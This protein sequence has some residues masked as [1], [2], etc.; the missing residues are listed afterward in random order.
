METLA[1]T[2]FLTGLTKFLLVAIKSLLINHTA[3]YLIVIFRVDPL[4]LRLN[5]PKLIETG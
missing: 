1:A 3:C 2:Q 5:V 4:A